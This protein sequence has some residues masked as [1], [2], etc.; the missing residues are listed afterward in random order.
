MADGAKCKTAKEKGVSVNG[1]SKARAIK[2]KGTSVGEG[3]GKKKWEDVGK[4]G[5]GGKKQRGGEVAK[6]YGSLR[7]YASSLGVIRGSKEVFDGKVGAVLATTNICGR[8]AERME[9]A[10]ELVGKG[11]IQAFA[12]FELQLGTEGAEALERKFNERW[13][14]HIVINAPTAEACGISDAIS[15]YCTSALITAR[16][17]SSTGRQAKASVAQVSGRVTRGVC[18]HKGDIF[19]VIA[20]KGQPGQGDGSKKARKDSE[21]RDTAI[22]NG[23][24]DG[25]K[26]YEGMPVFILMD[27]NC[28]IDGRDRTTKEKGGEGVN[29]MNDWDRRGMNTLKY[30]E[31]EGCVDY[32]REIY[33]DDEVGRTKWHSKGSSRIDVIYGNREATEMYPAQ[34]CSIAIGASGP[35]D[36]GVVLLRLC[37]KRGWAGGGCTGGRCGRVGK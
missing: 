14:A 13:G 37:E 16:S 21:S 26:A 10:V 28:V 30:L 31:K 1:A 12:N 6:R 18:K 25:L 29:E 33:I 36:H 20:V 8:A 32:W 19:G 4:E 23:I 17:N 9:A 22:I 15:G 27:A 34:K 35:G 3:G 24:G 7:E 2:K 5:R 11:E